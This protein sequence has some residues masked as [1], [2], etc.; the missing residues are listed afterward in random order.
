MQ[1]KRENI[2]RKID[3]ISICTDIISLRELAHD[4]ENDS[5]Y[6]R[7]EAVCRC[8][9]IVSDDNYEFAAKLTFKS[10]ISYKKLTL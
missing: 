2:I 3:F 9:R 4:S 8:Q 10:K 5:R 6:I 1:A 7:E